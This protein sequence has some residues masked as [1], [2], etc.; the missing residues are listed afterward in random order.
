MDKFMEKV[1]KEFLFM[2]YAPVVFASVKTG[3]RIENIFEIIT[4]VSNN[5]SLRVST[6]VLNDVLSRSVIKTP[7]PTHKGKRLKIYY[8][9]Q[10]AVKPPTFVF[11]VNKSE[12]FHFSYQHYLENNLRKTFGFEGTPIRFIIREKSEKNFERK[13]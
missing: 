5:N 12:L 11:F 2:S 8:M 1:K 6:G 9:T 7:P 13:I 10:V 4:K 3:Q